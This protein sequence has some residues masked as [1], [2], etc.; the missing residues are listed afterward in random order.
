LQD[1]SEETSYSKAT[2]YK[3]TVSHVNVIIMMSTSIK[4]MH[5]K[6]CFIFLKRYSSFTG[7]SLAEEGVQISQWIF[8][9][10]GWQKLA[11]F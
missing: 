4:T 2:E 8:I 11:L 3:T 5:L 9:I 7:K 1:Y 10:E 6:I